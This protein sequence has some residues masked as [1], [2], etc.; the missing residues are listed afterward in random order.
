MN[1]LLA[2]PQLNG[3]L[4]EAGSKLLYAIYATRQQKGAPES[5]RS[6]LREA[7]AR[8]VSRSPH[9]PAADAARLMIA[10]TSGS[11]GA[12]LAQLGQVS[13]AEAKAE[14]GRTAFG[15]IARD[16]S[17]AVARGKTAQGAGLARQG[18]DAWQ[19]LPPDDKKD[20]FNFP[21]ARYPSI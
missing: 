6:K 15:I 1:K 8:F 7:A 3:E 14:I 20:Q 17:A 21:A 10:Q 4:D 9:D 11:A 19:T 2:S 13:S 12:A 5:N 18:I 16:F